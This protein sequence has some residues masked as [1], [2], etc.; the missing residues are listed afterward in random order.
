MLV[1]HKSQH[2]AR[3][4]CGKGGLAIEQPI[5]SAM[6]LF[7]PVAVGS[8]YIETFVTVSKT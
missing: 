8:V 5:S 3:H 6:R 1:V 7:L 4:D 2:Y